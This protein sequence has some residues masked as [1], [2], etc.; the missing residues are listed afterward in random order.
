MRES[1][2]AKQAKKEIGN[3]I[4]KHSI[5][6]QEEEPVFNKDEI[7]KQKQLENYPR[8]KFRDNRYFSPTGN[9]T[10]ASASL[11]EGYLNKI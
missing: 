5:E 4:I 8:G 2:H 11:E 6:K 3:I 1:L 9:I 10:E 7:T